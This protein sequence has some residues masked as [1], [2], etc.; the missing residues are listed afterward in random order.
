VL[1][2]KAPRFQPPDPVGHSFDRWVVGYD[3]SEPTSVASEGGQMSA[4]DP[5]GAWWQDR[6]KHLQWERTE[7]SAPWFQM[8]ASNAAAGDSRHACGTRRT[9]PRRASADRRD[10]NARNGESARA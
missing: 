8:Q 1:R 10:E 6:L 5:A 2:R 3:E 4:D 9:R 7:G